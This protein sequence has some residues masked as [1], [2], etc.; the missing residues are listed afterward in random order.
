MTFGGNWKDIKSIPPA[1]ELENLIA[2]NGVNE[3]I[4][5]EEGLEAWDSKLI[6]YLKVVSDKAAE[7]NLGI[8]YSNLPDGIERLLKLAAAV[9]RKENVKEQE[10]DASLLNRVGT[11]S[12][13]FTGNILELIDFLG[14]T[15]IS[16][17]R[18]FIGKAQFRKFDLKLMIQE[19]GVNA[20]PIVSLINFLI[21]I[22]IAFVGALQLSQFGA[23][24]FVADLVGVAIVREMAPMMTAI[25]VAG[26]SGAA[27]AAHLGTMMVNEEIDAIN[28]LGFNPIDFLVLPRLLALIM[29]MPLLTLFAD[30]IGILGG[31]FVG[32]VIYDL[33]VGQYFE[34]TRSALTPIHFLLGIVKG[35]IYGM[36]VAIAGCYQG[37]QSGRSASAV[38]AAATSAVVMSIIFII[39]AS[40]V[41]TIIY[42]A[43][44]W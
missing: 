39:V 7:K 12:I 22:I 26:R 3:I 17:G 8:S 5:G 1:D 9:P 35:T 6:T 21:G 10:L 2:D 38:G 25:I 27:F 14:K 4:L 23:L 29:M 40:A 18:F 13:T 37:I 11:V 24:I 19:A 15:T 28:T 30:F 32:I 31:A 44:G 34:Q 41:T 20:L 36:L 33:P 43:F 42:S 16:L